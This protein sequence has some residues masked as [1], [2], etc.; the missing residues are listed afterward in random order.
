MLGVDK[1]CIRISCGTFLSLIKELNLLRVPEFI[2]GCDGVNAS[3]TNTETVSFTA[4]YTTLLPKDLAHLP[5]PTPGGWGTHPSRQGFE[6]TSYECPPPPV[7]PPRAEAMVHFLNELFIFMEADRQ[8]PPG[9]SDS[10]ESTCNAGDPGS[11]P[12]SG[13]SPGEENGYPFQYSCLENF[14][15]KGAW[16]ATVH[17]VAKSQTRLS[18]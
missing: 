9:G 16:W 17:G 13:R 8:R 7:R 11:I 2:S 12:G 3:S 1:I 5:S 10:K 14:M 15:D 4:P 18:D 6:G